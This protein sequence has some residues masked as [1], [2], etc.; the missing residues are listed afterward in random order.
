MK[1]IEGVTLYDMQDLMEVL[2][3][4][5]RSIHEYISRGKMRSVKFGRH[6]YVSSAALRDFLDGDYQGGEK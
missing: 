1:S 6:V 2:G 5:E 4:T 3:V